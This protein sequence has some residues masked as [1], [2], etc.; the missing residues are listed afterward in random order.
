MKF[1]CMG[2][3]LVYCG[4]VVGGGNLRLPWPPLGFVKGLVLSLVAVGMDGCLEMVAADSCCRRGAVGDPVTVSSIRKR[5]SSAACSF[6]FVSR[7]SLMYSTSMFHTAWRNVFQLACP[8]STF[9]LIIP[10]N[11]FLTC[12][13]WLLELSIPAP[14]TDIAILSAHAIWV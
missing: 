8:V 4:A 12:L 5:R 14:L 11:S 2:L 6:P 9:S 3:L 7:V 10:S 13:M 1:G